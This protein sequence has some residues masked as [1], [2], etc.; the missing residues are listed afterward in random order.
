MRND[1]A[2]ES[3]TALRAVPAS[4]DSS[5]ELDVALDAE[6]L[7]IDNGVP[8]VQQVPVARRCLKE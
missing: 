2:R 6:R 4:I 8:G 7:S 5:A 3:L 1:D